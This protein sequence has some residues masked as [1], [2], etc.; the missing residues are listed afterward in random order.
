MKQIVSILCTLAMI[1]CT[2]NVNLGNGK[3]GKVVTCEGPVVTNSF[4]FTDFDA[5]VVNGHADLEFTQTAE[6]YSVSVEANEEVFQHLNYR[7][8]GNTLILETLDKVNIRAEE[9]DIFISAPILKNIEI[10]GATDAKIASLHQEEKLEIEVNGAGDMELKYITVP[11][12][13]IEINGAA[14][15]ECQ[16]LDVGELT[17]EVNGA[18]DVELEGKAQNCS[19]NVSGA[20]DIDASKLDCAQIKTRKA[21]LA[22]IKTK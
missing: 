15:L 21:G 22:S 7:V 2:C 9:Y 13:S 1:G 8:E 19:L 18:G 5:I 4:A 11:G 12:L 16:G 17:I 6:T 20:A 10:N 3:N 14:D